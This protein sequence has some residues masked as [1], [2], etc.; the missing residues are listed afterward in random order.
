[1]FREDSKGFYRELGKKTIQIEKPPDIG[2]VKRFWQNIL[3]QEVK[4]NEDAQWIND[5]EE[6][7]QQINQMEWKDLTVEELRVNMT[8]AANWKSPG[9]D[10]LPNFWIKQFKSLHKPMT[11][12]YSEIVKDP[13]QTPD[14]LVEGATNLLPKKEETWI[15]KNYRPIACLPTTFKILTSVI[16]DRLY[17]HLE[18]E[19]IMT[20]EQ[21]GGKKDC[22]GC[23]DQLM[24]NNAILENCKKRKK[25]LS[26]AW[27]D[28]KK[29]FDSVPHS[30]ILKCLQMY[31]IHPVLITFIEESMSPMEDQHD[32]S[33]Q[34]RS[35]RDRTN[36]NQ[37]R[38]I[39]G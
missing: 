2:E 8:R 16:T 9:P 5:Q 38:D 17:S 10:R 11:E 6:E 33:P 1:M 20:P 15:P 13:K 34:G 29:A 36:K 24:I 26:T 18:K 30:W 7:L 39:P 19:A 14:W 21:R 32:T 28:Y 3:E 23:R 4:H 31:K 25:N 37:E 27:I 22:Y 12:A 35:S